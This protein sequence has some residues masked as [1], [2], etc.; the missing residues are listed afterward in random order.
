MSKIAPTLVEMKGYLLI[1]N[2]N[3][4]FLI[5]E[6]CEKYLKKKEAKSIEDFEKNT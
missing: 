6:N 3:K 4:I 2:K 1:R 5:I